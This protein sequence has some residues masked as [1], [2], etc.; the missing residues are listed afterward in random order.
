MG[1]LL[2]RG[3]RTATVWFRAGNCA[4]EFRRG[5]LNRLQGTVVPDRFWL[6]ALDDTP[7]PRYGPHV[8]GAGNHHN[9]TPGPT[10]QSYVY[11]HVWGTLARVVFRPDC[12]TLVLPLLADLHSRQVDLPKIDADRRRRAILEWRVGRYRECRASG[13]FPRGVGPCARRRRAWLPDRGCLGQRGRR[14]LEVQP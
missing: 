9:P 2:A 5:L 12:H 8:E 10:H 1:A 6:F 13:K 7:T 4:S 11:G 14:L 3:R